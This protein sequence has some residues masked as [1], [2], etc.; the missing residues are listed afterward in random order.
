MND[1]LVKFGSL[2][3]DAR[4][5]IRS[6][7]IRP[8]EHQCFANAARV[9]IN[10][11]GLRYAEGWVSTDGG[12]TIFAHAWVVRGEQEIDVTLPELPL[13]FTRRTFSSEEVLKAFLNR[14]G[15]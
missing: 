10:L 5:L 8:A 1:K 3:E 9:V 11:T 4:D 14:R 7:R 13:V 2:T 15:W 12:K 6:A